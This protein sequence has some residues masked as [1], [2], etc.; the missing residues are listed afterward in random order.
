MKLPDFQIFSGGGQMVSNYDWDITLILEND[1]VGRKYLNNKI[2]S[3]ENLL[4]ISSTILNI[5]SQKWNKTIK[6]TD[7]ADSF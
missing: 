6:Q 7:L 4:T 5:V 1:E 2:W 3:L